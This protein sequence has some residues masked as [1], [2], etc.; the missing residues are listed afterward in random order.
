M[1]ASIAIKPRSIWV[2]TSLHSF[3]WS[4]WQ[5]LLARTAKSRPLL[6]LLSASSSSPK[7]RILLTKLRER[8]RK[9]CGE[10]RASDLWFL[11]SSC[12]VPLST[13]VRSDHNGNLVLT[14]CRK[15]HRLDCGFGHLSH[16]FVRSQKKA[17]N[18]EFRSWKVRRNCQGYS[19][20][21]LCPLLPNF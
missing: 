10:R 17:C 8:R 16:R 14:H 2:G 3:S 4:V 7:D 13:V 21:T 11:S 1:C 6:H 20:H 15:R 18:S 19:I 9:S 12:W 5:S